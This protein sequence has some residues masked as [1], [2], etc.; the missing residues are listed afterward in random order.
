[1]QYPGRAPIDPDS[2]LIVVFKNFSVANP[3]RSAA[4][5]RPIEDDMEVCEIRIP[6]SRDIKVAP[7][8]AVSHKFVDPITGYER[9]ITY[10]ERFSYQYR[11]F[12]SNEAQTRTG[13]PLDYA[14][15]LTEARRAEL[16]ALN[17]YTL[18]A[19]AHV[20]GQELK[21]LGLGG[22]DMK[23]KAEEFMATAAATVGPSMKME[24][25]MEALQAKN[26]TLADD[27]ERLKA[28]RSTLVLSEKLFEHMT[29]E[30]LRAYIVSHT[31]H[32]PQGKLPIA[33]LQRMAAEAHKQEPADA[34]A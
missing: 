5:G 27:N 24:A 20:D 19:L 32:L 9:K 26:Q 15:F 13:T 14:P 33:T 22:R 23:N 29:I 21:N 1:M 10:A 31:G 12:K 30:Q 3:A 25:E 8:T 11:Q 18:E 16:R 2:V 17:I 4:E 7:A 34:A 6:G 28:T